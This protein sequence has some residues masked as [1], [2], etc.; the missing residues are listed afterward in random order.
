MDGL[1]APDRKKCQT[2]HGSRDFNCGTARLYMF[3]VINRC[4]LLAWIL[5]A[6]TEHEE[7]KLVCRYDL[8]NLV[9]KASKSKLIPYK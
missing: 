7:M 3:W 2:K 6:Y 8:L 1:P 5:L 9:E 4:C